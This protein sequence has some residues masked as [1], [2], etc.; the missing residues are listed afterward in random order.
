MNEWMNE[1]KEESPKDSVVASL[2]SRLQELVEALQ[3][4]EIWEKSVFF[5]DL[6]FGFF[7][8]FC[9]WAQSGYTEEKYEKKTGNQTTPGKRLLE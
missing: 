2:H 4:Q 9:V 7:L 5:L 8:W 1:W 6:C 3:P